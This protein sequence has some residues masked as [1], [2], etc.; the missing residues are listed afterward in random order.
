MTPHQPIP[1]AD[2]KAA[3]NA[4]AP[5]PLGALPRETR[6]HL[7]A[8]CDAALAGRYCHGCGEPSL[9]AEDE[10]LGHFLREQFEE[11]TG[12][13]GKL[14]RTLRALPVPGKLTAEYFNGRR[15]LYVRPVRL[16]L[17]V[18]I[19]LFFLLSFA[20]GNFLQAPLELTQ[21]RPY[22]RLL[23]PAVAA[24]RAAWKVTP[25]VYAAHFNAHGATLTRS[26][27]ILLVP[28]LAALLVVLLWRVRASGLR[29]LVF[30]THSVATVL[31]GMVAVAGAVMLGTLA[32]VRMTGVAFPYSLDPVIV[33]IVLALV[34]LYFT[35]GFRRVYRLRWRWAVPAGL[36]M[37][38]GGMFVLYTAY[39]VVLAVLTVATLNPPVR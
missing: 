21:Q 8:A 31:A 32:W 28:M 29:H 34:L 5:L 15:G 6:P 3:A 7:C 36:L 27:V 25:E 4:A 23:Q 26:L 18:N 2:V 24:Q 10:S 38:T 9:G 33:P 1:V 14:A 12:A 13:D 35:L 16:F 39:Q 22:W 20:N 19:A 11:V 37:G 17:A 30:A